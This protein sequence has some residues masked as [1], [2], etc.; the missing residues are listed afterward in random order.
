[1][2]TIHSDAR[3]GILTS[4]KLDNYLASGVGIN[5]LD[6]QLRTPLLYAINPGHTTIVKLL[7]SRGASVARGKSLLAP[8]YVAARANKNR[9]EIVRL[10]LDRNPKVDEPSPLSDNETPLMAAIRVKDPVVVGM[11]IDA[12]ASLQAKSD[13]GETARSMAQQSND[14]AIQKFALP[15]GQQVK[16]LP[17]LINLAVHLVL[18]ILAY[19]NSGFIDGVVKGVVSNLYHIGSAEPDEKL[20]KEI[21][22]PQTVDDFKDAIEE[23]VNNHNLGQFFPPGDDYVQKVA[24]KAVELKENPKNNFG[25]PGQIETLFKLALHQPIFYCDDSGSMNGE[26]Y[27]NEGNKAGT[28][29]HVMRQLVQRMARITTELVPEGTGCHLRFINSNYHGNN[30]GPGQIDAQLQF[31]PYG[32]TDL[33]THL[34]Q[35]VLK[36]IIYD[37]LDK[38]GRLERPYLVLT[39][40]D[41]EPNPEPIDSFKKAVQ[42][43]GRRLENRDYP[44]DAV[45]FLISQVGNDK[46]AD[47]FLDSLNGDTALDRVLYRTS[48]RLHEKYAALR[49]NEADLDRWA[50]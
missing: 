11:L 36:P 48:E 7:L 29:M 6:G 49:H 27:D 46:A 37:Q 41:G 25:E 2:A 43:C 38:N 31:E 12:G 4:G 34:D 32:G 19:F 18:F 1:M 35:K 47:V 42:G 39:I 20:A 14:P 8:L 21:G 45:M 44:Q 10:L 17:E 40:T 15:P 13:K 50:S 3:K 24:E 5:D 23:Y 33:G 28:R 16:G 22:N 30:L 26:I 9:A